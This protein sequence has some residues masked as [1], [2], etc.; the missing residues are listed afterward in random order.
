MATFEELLIKWKWMAIRDCPGRYKMFASR[1]DLVPEDLLGPEVEVKTFHVPGAR[2]TVLVASLV[3]GG[4]LISYKRA[5]GSHL[6][7]L[8]TEEG[9]ERKLIDLGIEPRKYL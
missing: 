6:H 5:D 2:D 4:G 7:T 9:F 1:A 3:G 8:N